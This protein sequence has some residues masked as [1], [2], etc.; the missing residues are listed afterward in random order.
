MSSKRKKKKTF[1]THISHILIFDMHFPQNKKE[2]AS[3]R[4]VLIIGRIATRSKMFFH[5]V[6]TPFYAAFSI[7]CCWY[8]S[9]F[10]LQMRSPFCL[11]RVVRNVTTAS[12]GA[13]TNRCTSCVCYSI[14]YFLKREKNLHMLHISSVDTLI[15]VQITRSPSAL[16]FTGNI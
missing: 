12:E 13:L 7:K 16:Y 11:V 3:T 4:V 5:V 9:N 2:I 8:N 1:I 10:D 15:I 6:L 14:V